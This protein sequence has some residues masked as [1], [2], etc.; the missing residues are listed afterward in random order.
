MRLGVEGCWAASLW[1]QR[2][3]DGRTVRRCPAAHHTKL[4]N[5]AFSVPIIGVETH[6]S[7]CFYH[8]VQATRGDV[9]R[10]P[11]GAVVNEVF[12]P[13]ALQAYSVKRATRRGAAIEV[14][15]VRVAHLAGLS[16]RATSLGASAPAAGVVPMALHRK[17]GVRCVS[18]SDERAM[19]A[20]LRFA[21]T[22]MAV[23]PFIRPQH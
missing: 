16:S 22:L 9:S 14:R 2:T 10:L 21:G 4:T 6:G 11:A 5:Y 12:V 20:A 18:V 1:E 19:D 7:A 15:T 13:D 17:G 23:H 8:S 3:W